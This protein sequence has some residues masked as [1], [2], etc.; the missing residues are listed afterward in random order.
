MV[1]LVVAVVPLV[2]VDG[3]A[4]VPVVLVVLV[5]VVPVVLVYE[6]E[7]VS[8]DAVVDD[9]VDPVASVPVVTF[10]FDSFVQASANT[11]SAAANKIAR[12]FFMV[13]FPLLTKTPC[14]CSRASLPII[15]S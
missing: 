14:F 4:D 12:D 1:V 3:A 9:D 2:P 13:G 7:L 8:D 15:R 5:A 10:V 11:V 6:D